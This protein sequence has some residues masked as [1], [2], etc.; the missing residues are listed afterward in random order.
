MARRKKNADLAPWQ[1]DDGPRTPIAAPAPG[2]CRFRVWWNGKEHLQEYALWFGLRPDDSPCVHM[3]FISQITGKR[4]PAHHYVIT[5]GEGQTVCECAHGK[6]TEP[7][8]HRGAVD[9][10]LRFCGL[11]ADQ[12]TANMLKEPPP[13]EAPFGQGVLEPAPF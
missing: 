3:E 5:A 11:I 13:A 10:L 6:G 4:V 2:H 7:C 9:A 8:L 1:S 12:I